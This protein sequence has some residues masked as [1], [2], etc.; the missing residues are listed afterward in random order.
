MVAARPLAATMESTRLW[1]SCCDCSCARHRSGCRSRQAASSSAGLPRERFPPLRLSPSAPSPCASS[2]PLETLPG[3]IWPEITTGISG[4]RL[5]RFY[6]SRKLHTGEA[7]LRR[8]ESSEVDPSQ[9]YW[10]SQGERAQ[11][12]CGR[13]GAGLVAPGLDGVQLMELGVHDRS[14][15]RRPTRRSCSTRFGRGSGSTPCRIATPR[16][17]AMRRVT[18]SSRRPLARSRNEARGVSR[19]ARA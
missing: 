6:H 18:S 14:S 11:S 5:A 3:A 13:P 9:F 7:R 8:I 12:R 2:N 1:R 19:P 17:G 4:G 10:V 15:R 16:M